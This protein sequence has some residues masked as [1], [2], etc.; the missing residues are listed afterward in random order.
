MLIKWTNVKWKPTLLDPSMRL[1]KWI[2][3]KFIFL[4]NNGSPPYWI[5]PGGE[6]TRWLAILPWWALR[7]HAPGNPRVR[8]WGALGLPP[9]LWPLASCPWLPS[10]LPW[11]RG[12]PAPLPPINSGA[13]GRRRTHNSPWVG[14][15]PLLLMRLHLSLSSP[16]LPCGFPKRRVGAGST[17]MLHTVV[18]WEFRIRSKQS[19]FRNLCCIGV[20]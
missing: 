18:L 4:I 19:Y 16:S 8:V 9:P 3:I 20:P 2:N 12:M 10:W 11:W 1:I 7:C 17:L 13:P 14:S 15:S 5:P 6:P